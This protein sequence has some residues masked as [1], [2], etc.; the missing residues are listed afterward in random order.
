MHRNYDNCWV[1]HRDPIDLMDHPL[2]M[3]I[4]LSWYQKGQKQG[5]LRSYYSFDEI[6][7]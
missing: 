7:I 4:G 2:K 5:D 1:E 6:F 3:E